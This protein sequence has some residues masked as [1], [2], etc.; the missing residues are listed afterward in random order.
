MNCSILKA[1]IVILIKEREKRE[2]SRNTLHK[3]GTK[4]EKEKSSKCTDRL[5]T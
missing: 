4:R 1:E 5:N 2:N 3:E